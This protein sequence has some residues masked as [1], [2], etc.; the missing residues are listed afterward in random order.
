MAVDWRFD[1]VD[2]AGVTLGELTGAQARRHSRQPNGMATASGQI[3]LSSERAADLLAVR[4]A[5]RLL[6]AYRGSKLMLDGPVIVIVAE[7][8]VLAVDVEEIVPAFRQGGLHLAAVDRD[9]HP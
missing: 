6:K 8:S 7:G 9:R 3:R 5:R 2:G 1:L 4:Q